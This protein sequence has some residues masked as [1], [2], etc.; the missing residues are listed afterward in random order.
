MA[1][2]ASEDY[3]ED[4]PLLIL[5]MFLFSVCEEYYGRFLYCE[6]GWLT[7]RVFSTLPRFPK[8]T[9]N[10]HCTTRTVNGER[11]GAEPVPVRDG[12]IILVHCH[13]APPV[14]EAIRSLLI[15][16][17]SYV[18]VN[19]DRIITK[20][21]KVSVKAVNKN[22]V[23][24]AGTVLSAGSLTFSRFGCVSPHRAARAGASGRP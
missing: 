11:V 23:A 18:R 20:K 5:Q 4:Q 16:D 10:H 17:S 6:R 24:A 19:V 2:E 12:D 1:A 7:G 8:G 15:S 14:G 13:G 22:S 3:F 9:K 21:I